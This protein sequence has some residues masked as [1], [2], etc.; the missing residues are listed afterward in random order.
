MNCDSLFCG[1]TFYSAPEP[2]KQFF[3]IIGKVE[4]QSKTYVVAVGLLKGKKQGLYEKVFAK[5]KIWL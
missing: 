1:G 5:I 3:E 2:F 4:N